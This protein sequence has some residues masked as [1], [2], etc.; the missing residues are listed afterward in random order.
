MKIKVAF[1]CIANLDRIQIE[2]RFFKKHTNEDKI[3]NLVDK[4][5]D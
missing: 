2:Y 1:I 4:A 5:R 3:R